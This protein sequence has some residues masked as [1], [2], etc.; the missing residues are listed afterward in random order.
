MKQ[1]AIRPLSPL[2]AGGQGYHVFVVQ[3]GPLS[4]SLAKREFPP[5]NVKSV[6]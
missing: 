6:A 3:I 4:S 5:S 1:Y 2:P